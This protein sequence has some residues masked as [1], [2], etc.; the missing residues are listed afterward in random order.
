MKFADASVSK[1]IAELVSKQNQKK[2]VLWAAECAEHVLPY[3]EEACPNDHRPREAIE[4]GRA[5]VRGE[6]VMSEARTAAFAAHA[7]ARDAD[8]TAVSAVVNRLHSCAA[9]RAAGHAAA[10][11]HVAGHAV[12]AATYAAKAAA[13]A[14]EAKDA[15][16]NT[17]KEREWQ[18]QRLLDIAVT[19]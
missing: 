17:T 9:A 5:W 2:L 16:A 13:Y 7:A 10:T 19:T 4:A 18:Y 3:F 11:A 12:H 15:D 8:Q 14:A 1:S 6:I